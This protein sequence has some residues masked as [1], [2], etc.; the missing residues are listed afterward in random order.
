[1]NTRAERSARSILTADHHQ[2]DGLLEN[3]I[4]ALKTGER[5]QA[6]VSVD[7]FWAR[8]AMHIRAEHLHLFPALEATS[9][10]THD[11]DHIVTILNGLREDHNFFMRELLVLIKQ[12]RDRAGN[13]LDPDRMT[14]SMLRIQERLALHNEIEE[15]QVYPL[16]ARDPASAD[17]ADICERVEF[18]IT[19]MPP[20]FSTKAET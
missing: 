8:L 16:A 15:T 4:E 1:M 19:N 11:H 17:H 6:M 12:L 20:R 7:I 5:D 18:E 10:H 14:R 9:A 2:L 3:A 13:A